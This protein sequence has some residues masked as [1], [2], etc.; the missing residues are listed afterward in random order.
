MAKTKNTMR[1]TG[2][3]GQLISAGGQHLAIKLPPCRS[4]RLGG[5]DANRT[6]FTLDEGSTSKGGSSRSK[7]KRDDDDPNPKPGKQPRQN[8][9]TKN[10]TRIPKPKAKLSMSELCKKW[11]RKARI[12]LTSETK[13][14]WLK[15][16]DQKR[17]Q[18]GH[19][20]QHL[21]PGL[22]AL[23]EIKF[24]Q[25]CQAFLIPMLQFSHLV[26]EICQDCEFHENPLRWQVNAIFS[27]NVRPR[28]TLLDF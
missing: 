3:K 19:V 20:L 15:K 25:R 6:G 21:V 10:L 26:R 24:Y 14:A 13:K 2:N 7:R 17:D 12:G 27:F 4:A 1:K 11:N 8:I 23:R 9:P 28:H 22:T 5:H 18:Q 16:T